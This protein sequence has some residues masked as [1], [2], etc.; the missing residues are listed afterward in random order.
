MKLPG[1]N[2]GKIDPELEDWRDQITTIINLGKVQ[3]PTV[4]VA[5]T[6]VG[7]KGEMTFVMPTSGGTTLYVMRN[8]AWVALLS[9]TI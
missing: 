1:Y 2:F 9:V 6:W 7:N 3:L 4:T 5:P 8:T